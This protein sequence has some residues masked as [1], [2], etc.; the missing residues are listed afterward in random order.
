MIHITDQVSISEA[1]IK[2]EFIKSSGPGGQNI[3]KVATA[4]Q[5]RFNVVKSPSIPDDV[6]TRLLKILGNKI[7]DEGVLIIDSRRFRSQLRNREEALDRL[8][9]L[10]KEAA[11][12]PKYRIKTK[13]PRAEKEK[14]LKDKKLRS[15]LK[16]QRKRVAIDE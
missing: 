5:L 13:L 16:I 2:E 12:K 6:K 11:Q 10:I 7:T 1:E 14:R 15:N 4:V 3:N 8:I 9:D